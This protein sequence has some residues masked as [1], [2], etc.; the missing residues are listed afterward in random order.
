MSSGGL[1]ALKEIFH[2][3]RELPPNERTAFLD[4]ACGS[5]EQLRREVETLLQSHQAADGFFTDPPAQLA[6]EAIDR[7]EE[8]SDVGKTVGPYQLI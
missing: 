7:A 3:A 5:D 8:L 6:A 4:R 2:S 1:E